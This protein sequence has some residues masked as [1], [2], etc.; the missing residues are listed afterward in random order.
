M[1]DAKTSEQGQETMSAYQCECDTSDHK[2]YV[3]TYHDGTTEI[4]SY[5]DDCADLA[6][7]DWN[8]ETASI[9]EHD[10]R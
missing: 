4:V 6:R 1:V 7:L 9:V 2:I 10:R 3:V 8:G 5:C